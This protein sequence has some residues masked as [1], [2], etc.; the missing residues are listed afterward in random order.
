[1]KKIFTLALCLIALPAAAHS[2]HG[3]EL[4]F[5]AGLAHPFTGLDH[6]LAML[7]VGMW[8]RRQGQPLSLPLTFLA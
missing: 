8:S 6:L 2:G 3:P 5:A 7:G 1:M 4:G